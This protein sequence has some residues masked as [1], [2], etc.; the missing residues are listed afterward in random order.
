[1][2][3]LHRRRNATGKI[4]VG[5]ALLGSYLPL[6][7]FRRSRALFEGIKRRNR[8]RGI[9]YLRMSEVQQYKPREGL[10]QY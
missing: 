7:L 4:Q 10:K 9:V 6:E 8:G 3:Q 2:S 1:M 5:V